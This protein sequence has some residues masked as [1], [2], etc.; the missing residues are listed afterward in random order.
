MRSGSVKSF[1]AIERA[2]P[3]GA[4]EWGWCAALLCNAVLHCIVYIASIYGYVCSSNIHNLL[5][6]PE[7]HV[8]QSL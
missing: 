5:A 2:P 1:L 3:P 4:V 7:M 8:T 6:K